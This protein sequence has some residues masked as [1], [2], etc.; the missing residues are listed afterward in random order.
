[1][2]LSKDIHPLPPQDGAIIFDTEPG[3]IFSVRN[4]AN[5]IPAYKP[6]GESTENGVVAAI[7]YA[8]TALKTPLLLVMGH[9]QCGG[10]A[11]AL[12]VVTKNRD[13]CVAMHGEGGVP[14]TVDRWCFTMKE[15]VCGVIDKF[16][17]QIRGR[18]L[19]LENVRL[20]V[21]RVSEYPWV[22]DAVKAGT[23]QV[24]GAFFQV[25][26]GRLFVLGTD[27]DFYDAGSGGK[28]AERVGW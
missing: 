24:R 27:D 10:C 8:V 12:N 13:L 23:L 9:S 28:M 6:P 4:V 11:H 5:M 19:E 17:P 1:M 26:D 3:D 16:D 22:K 15:A 2:S 21:K 14:S 18:Q 25:F 7:E 20:S